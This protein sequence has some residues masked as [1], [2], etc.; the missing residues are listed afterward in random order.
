MTGF[1]RY[2]GILNAAVW[3]GAAVFFTAGVAPGVFSADTRKL[4]GD[5]AFPYYA[6]GVALVLFKRY[7]LAHYVCGSLALLHLL[8]EWLCLGRRTSRWWLGLVAALL[9]LGLLGG[10]WMQPKMA[11][12]R[13]T[14]YHAANPEIREQA[15]HKFG[16]W[17]GVAQGVNLL[18]I[19][20]LAI[21]TC[22]MV[23]PAEAVRFGGFAQFRG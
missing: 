4:F 8:A 10:M 21:Y 6:G 2:A 23:R 18:V 12:L 13:E 7:F 20:G 1:L 15:R 11:V 14:M 3:L 16:A 9:G 17:H 19:A 5:T 22:R